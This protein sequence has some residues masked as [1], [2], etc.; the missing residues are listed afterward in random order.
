[1]E[2]REL[3]IGNKILLG[4]TVVDV[5]EIWDNGLRV[6]NSCTGC[7]YT[8]DQFS[9]IILT[10]KWL[11]RFGFKVEEDKLITG[12][13]L[14]QSYSL[15]DFRIIANDLTSYRSLK[16]FRTPFSRNKIEHVHQLQNL[17]FALTGKELE[18]LK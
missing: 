15:N 18:L 16:S 4:S 17:Y 10:E 9:P 11:E 14:A 8:Y 3:R 6:T 13:T 5:I 2:I 7:G 1:M 12:E